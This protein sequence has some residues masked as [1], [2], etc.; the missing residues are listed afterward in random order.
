MKS[1]GIAC[2]RAKPTL[3]KMEQHIHFCSTSDGVRIAYA[4]VGEGP[5]VVKAANWLNHLEFDWQSPI[6]RHL[7]EEF[8]RDHLLVRYDER[9]NGLSDWDVEDLSFDKFASHV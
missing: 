1:N 2:R 9:G 3:G 5:P 7:L 6:W 4:T 8:A